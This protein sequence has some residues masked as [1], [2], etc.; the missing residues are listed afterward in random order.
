M[1]K[2]L[3]LFTILVLISSCT[4]TKIG[5]VDVQEVMKDYDAAKSIE[6]QLKLEQDEMSKSLD[7]LMIPFQVKVQ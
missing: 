4:Q 3:I 7:S 2:L 1:R 5:Y 6:E